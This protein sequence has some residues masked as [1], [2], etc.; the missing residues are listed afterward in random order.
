MTKKLDSLRDVVREGIPVAPIAKLLGIRLVG[1]EPGQARLEFEA[2]AREHANPMGT[3][4]GGVLCDVADLAMGIAFASTLEEDEL[5]TTL[6]LKINFLQAIRDAKLFAEG[7]V[8][9]RGKNVGLAECDVTDEQG[10]L[11]ARASSTCMVLR[12]NGKSS[13]SI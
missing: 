10:R 12:D 2:K 13:A 4:H 7:K 11:V 9:R 1:I 8:V 5:F 3:L 6:E